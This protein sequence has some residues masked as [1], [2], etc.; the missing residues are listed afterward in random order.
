MK[1]QKSACILQGLLV[2]GLLF[3]F[4][5]TTAGQSFSG[6]KNLYQLKQAVSD[7]KSSGWI[8]LSSTYMVHLPVRANA[9]SA[10][11]SLPG[12]L[13]FPSAESPSPALHCPVPTGPLLPR[14][15]AECLPFFCRIEHDLS[16][17]SAVPVKFRLG[18][19]EYVDWLEGKGE[20]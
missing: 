7:A 1:A 3:A 12:N 5:P 6:G 19:V 18:S 14:W 9:A 10:A 4:C 13:P 17:K 8:L 2:A 15:S 16:R 11:F 20:W